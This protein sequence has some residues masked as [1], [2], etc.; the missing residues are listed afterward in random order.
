MAS[1]LVIALITCSAIL[2]PVLNPDTSPHRRWVWQAFT[3]VLLIV[4]FWN[5]MALLVAVCIVL[6]DDRTLIGLVEEGV[7]FKLRTLLSP[8]EHRETR[9]SDST[10]NAPTDGPSLPGSVSDT[11]SSE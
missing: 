10:G 9:V 1:Y 4:P 2:Y 8:S 3:T 5:E 7:F 11:T 6:C